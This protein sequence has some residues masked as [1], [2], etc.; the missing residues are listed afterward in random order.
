MNR[1]SRRLVDG[2][3][4]QPEDDGAS[5]SSTG[6]VNGGQISYRESPVRI[7]KKKVAGRRQ[8][9]SSCCLAHENASSESLG[10]YA[11][12]EPIRAEEYWGIAP[13]L[14]ALSSSSRASSRSKFSS[15]GPDSQPGFSSRFS[16]ADGHGNSSGY[17]SSEEGCCGPA[18]PHPDTE[19]QLGVKDLLLSPGRALAMLYWWLG[20]AW[21][22][23]TTGASL[24]DVFLLT[25][26]TGTVKK[27]IALLLLLVLLALG[28]WYWYPFLA[29]SSGGTALRS[30]RPVDPVDSPAGVGA[31]QDAGVL[32][33]LSALE[34]ELEVM[35]RESER[36]G[37]RGA[38]GAQQISAAVLQSTLAEREESWREERERVQKEIAQLKQDGET[39]R[40]ET[41]GNLQRLSE[42]VQAEVSD[43]KS[44]LKSWQS[45]DSARALEKLARLEQEL[46]ALQTDLTTLHTE[47]RTLRDR[48]DNLD[49]FKTQMRSELAEWLAQYLSSPP[50]GAVPVVLRPELQEAL[51][52]LE[53]KILAKMS[54]GRG[55]E[56]AWA[57]VGETLKG[58]GVGEVTLQD[59]HR[60]V[61]R[62]LALYRADGIGLADYALESAGASVVNTR[63]SETYETKTALLSLF[64]IPMWYHSQSPRTIIQPDVNP[65]NCWAFRGSHGFA[66]I[67]LSTPIRPTA[68]SLEHIPKVLSPSGRIDSA[69]RD[70]TVYGMDDEKQEEGTLLGK[71]TYDQDGDSIQTFTLPG[72]APEAYPLVELRVLSNWGHP[73][74][75]CVYRFRVHGEAP[76]A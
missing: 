26:H 54:Q 68:V 45:E 64:G 23:L 2:G 15:P 60:I 5:T 32:A 65:G 3:Y 30:P 43:L 56:G 36:E 6:S 74:Y 72:P 62:A 17:S 49:A 50:D 59:V 66:V 48:L 21:Y 13:S 19:P 22:S 35:K 51:Q 61:R 9:S 41:V 34:G 70:F 33:R 40:K 58:E 71:F 42:R 14:R 76:S 37:P 38:G 47:Q 8:V 63:C 10:S 73:E 18:Q 55:G 7:F 75:T 53:E 20:T 46:T 4:Y 52:R 57:S 69:P 11:S 12:E 67:Q 16:A 39:I 44:S 29:L 25:R 28:A 1:R 27:T 31:I 24:L